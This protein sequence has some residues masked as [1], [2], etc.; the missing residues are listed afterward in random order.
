MKKLGSHWTD[1][2][3]IWDLCIFRKPVEKIQVSLKHGKNN[4]YSTWRPIYIFHHISLN[5]SKNE[6]YFR[7]KLYRKSKHTH[8]KCNNCFFENRAVYD[9]MWKNILEPDRPQVTI[10]CMRIAFWVTKATNTLSGISNTYCFSTA[11]MVA[12]TRLN[13]TLY[14]PCLLVLLFFVWWLT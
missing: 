12:R 2:H 14:V 10:W 8:F 1:F 7:Q 6:K 5:F 3:E 13:V 9:I 11:A 4:G